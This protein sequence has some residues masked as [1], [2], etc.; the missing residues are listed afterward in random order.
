MSKPHPRAL[1]STGDLLLPLTDVCVC[2]WPLEMQT[3][4]PL[5]TFGLI[6]A[7]QDILTLE[8]ADPLVPQPLIIVSAGP[9]NTEMKWKIY[10]VKSYS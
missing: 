5:C 4:Q 10:I 1:K 9:L 2:V 3:L 8:G 6:P 7:T